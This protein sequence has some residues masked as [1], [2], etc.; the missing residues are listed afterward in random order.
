VVIN[1]ASRYED[2]TGRI[3]PARN[4]YALSA[5][6]FIFSALV[7]TAVK[8]VTGRTGKE[9]VRAGISDGIHFFRAGSVTDLPRCPSYTSLKIH[10]GAD[11]SSSSYGDSGILCGI[12]DGGFGDSL[13]N[14]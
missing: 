12:S 3:E 2:V 1:L 6:E 10:N 4:S 11:V 13:W 7:P 8:D 5:T 14:Q 9:F